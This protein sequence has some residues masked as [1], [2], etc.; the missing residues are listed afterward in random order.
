MSPEARAILG[1]IASASRKKPHD[2][3]ADHST[4]SGIPVR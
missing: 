1:R 2:Q 4:D 3:H